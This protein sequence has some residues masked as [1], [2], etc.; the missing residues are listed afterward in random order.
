MHC[1]QDLVSFLSCGLI[2]AGVWHLVYHRK[3]QSS[4]GRYMACTPA[5]M[6]P[7]RLA[8]FLQEMPA[9][10]IPLLLMLNTHKST[11]MGKYLLLATFCVH[12]FQR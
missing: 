7:A 5:R 4:Y 2:L 12:Y 9:F 1:H 6:V 8:W 11:I 10:I 3:T